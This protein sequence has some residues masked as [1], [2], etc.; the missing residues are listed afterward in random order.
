MNP[1]F[2][3]NLDITIVS[4]TV[5]ACIVAVWFLFRKSSTHPPGLVAA[6]SGSSNGKSGKGAV[7]KNVKLTEGVTGK[8]FSFDP[9]HSR[10]F[11]GALIPDAPAYALTHSLSMVAWIQPRGNGY[12]IFFRGDHRPG[13]DPY[14]LSMQGNHDLRFWLC[15]ASNDDSAFIDTEIPYFVWTQVAATLDGGTGTMRLYT[16]G[17]L[18]VQTNT[19][20]RPFGELMADQTPGVGIGNLNDGGNS[21]PFNGKI[22]GM[23]LY[24]R[25]LSAN[26][27]EASYAKYAAKAESMNESATA[28]NN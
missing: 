7:L 16:N 26:E 15:G 19:T 24:D 13:L 25:A 4:L 9:E 12:M 28:L 18:A 11:T 27:V 20:V 5:I 21:F 2:K 14:G 6:W 10:G 1:S 8:A 22:D 23:E 17:V 3:K